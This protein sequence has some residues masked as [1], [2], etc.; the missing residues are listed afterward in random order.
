MLDEFRN[1]DPEI[2]HKIV[3]SNEAQ[4][5]LNELVNRHN[6]I[7]YDTVNPRITFKK[8]LNQPGVLV[9]AGMSSF[10]G[11]SLGHTFLKITA[12]AHCIMKCYTIILLLVSERYM[13]TDSLAFISNKRVLRRIMLKW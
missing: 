3:F 2:F 9:W 10:G 6:S 12:P 1:K 13:K 7:Y 11:G 5:K 8:Q 4:F